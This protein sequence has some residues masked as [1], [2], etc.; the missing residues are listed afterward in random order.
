MSAQPPKP[1]GNFKTYKGI[2]RPRCNCIPCREKF[3]TNQ[4]I[5][6]KGTQRILSEI[7]NHNGRLIEALLQ[8]KKVMRQVGVGSNIVN[9]ALKEIEGDRDGTAQHNA[10]DP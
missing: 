10:S 6:I 5:R 3:I 7:I 4:D 8:A 2:H 9:T 1:C